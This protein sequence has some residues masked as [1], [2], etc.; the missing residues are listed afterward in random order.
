M[1]LFNSG[2]GTRR[3]LFIVIHVLMN[4]REAHVASDHNLVAAG[5]R[6]D[7]FVRTCET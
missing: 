6:C 7:R 1:R 5:L 4:P 2:S 3:A